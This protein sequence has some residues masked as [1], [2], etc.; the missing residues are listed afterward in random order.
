M[1]NTK[2]T[3]LFFALSLL[4]FVSWFWIQHKIWP[5][6]ERPKPEPAAAKLPDNPYLWGELSVRAALAA[7]PGVPGIGSASILAAEIATAEK[8]AKE[9]KDPVVARKAEPKR[10]PVKEEPAAAA[11]PRRTFTLGDDN[12]N[13]RVVVTSHGAGVQSVTLNKFQEADAEGRPVW[14]DQAKKVIKPL[15]LISNSEI[16][17]E[18]SNLLFHF[19]PNNDEDDRPLAKLGKDG[20]SYDDKDPVKVLRDDEGNVFEYA[21]T[22]TYDGLP[23]VTISKTYTLRPVDYHVGLAVKIKRNNTNPDK[24]LRF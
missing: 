17:D 14:K 2:N 18:P 12:T 20:W 11:M 24:K 9:R 22:L 21:V 15:E 5:P 8:A 16:G 19:R 1:Q 13:L 4:I 6:L 10:E 3:L 7:T 23:D